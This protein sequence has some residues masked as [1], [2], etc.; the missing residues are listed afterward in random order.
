V[1][2]VLLNCSPSMPSQSS[3]PLSLCIPCLLFLSFTHL[4]QHNQTAQPEYPNIQSLS[5]SF[6]PSFPNSLSHSTYP[7]FPNCSPS[8]PKLLTQHSQTAHPAYL[9]IQFFSLPVLSSLILYS[10]I[11][12]TN[13]A[14][15]KLLNQH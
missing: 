13:P 8:I 7:A 14:I 4:S 10:L 11:H 5:L 1:C 12:S 15:P 6:H 2:W 9:N 3:L